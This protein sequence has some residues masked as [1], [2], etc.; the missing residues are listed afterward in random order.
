M[1][2]SANVFPML[3]ERLMRDKQVGEL[4]PFIGAFPGIKGLPT[5]RAYPYP[6]S[7]VWVDTDAQALRIS[8]NTPLLAKICTEECAKHGGANPADIQNAVNQMVQMLTDVTSRV[9][10]KLPPGIP[11]T[12]V[13]PTHP[14]FPLQ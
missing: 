2:P 14:D 11:I 10:Q 8:V 6:L 7:Y 9:M 3:A 12:E 13:F 1:I 5:G 4:P